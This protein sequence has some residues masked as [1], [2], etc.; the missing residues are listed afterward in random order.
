MAFKFEELKVWQ[1]ALELTY[2]IHE[3]TLSFPKEAIIKMIQAL[4]NSLE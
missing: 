3:L 2:E 4:R 1:R